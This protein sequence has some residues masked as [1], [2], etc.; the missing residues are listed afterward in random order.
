MK[1]KLIVDEPWDFDSGD[2]TNNIYGKINESSCGTRL[3]KRRI[4]YWLIFHCDHVVRFKDKIFRSLLFTPRYHINQPPL[5]LLRRGEILIFNAM[6]RSDGGHWDELSVKQAHEGTL[7][8]DGFI[9]VSA[10][11]I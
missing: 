9:I 2:G 4:E 10:Q 5:E 8:V 11:K 6:L 1:V 7:K 3:I